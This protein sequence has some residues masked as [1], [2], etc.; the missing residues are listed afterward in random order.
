[1]DIEITFKDGTVRNY[2]D[3]RRPGGSYRQTIKSIPGFIVIKD[4]WG[5]VTHIA[6]DTIKEIKYNEER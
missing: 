5:N 2:K 1:M 4:V 6:D 3:E